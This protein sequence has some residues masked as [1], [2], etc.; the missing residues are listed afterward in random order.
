[1]PVIANF[2]LLNVCEDILCEPQEG[3]SATDRDIFFGVLAQYTMMKRQ[4]SEQERA[5]K[6]KS[7]NERER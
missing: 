4:H 6:S 1:M 7:K 3:L 5:T 2:L